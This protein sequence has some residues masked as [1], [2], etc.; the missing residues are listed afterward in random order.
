MFGQVAA[1]VKFGL[2]IEQAGKIA[3]IDDINA[4]T[5]ALVIL[6][7]KVNYPM[8][9]GQSKEYPDGYKRRNIS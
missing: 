7:D 6:A 1:T 5:S 9:N 3:N 4:Y 8:T 2:P